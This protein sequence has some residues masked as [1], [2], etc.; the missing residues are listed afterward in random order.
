MGD[1][2]TTSSAMDSSSKTIRTDLLIVGAG[3]AGASLASFLASHNLTGILLASAPGTA[4]T[5]RAHI[6]NMA[7][8]ECLRDID[9]ERECLAL[10]SPGS[11]MQHTRWCRTMAGEEYARIYS[12]GNDP[13]RRGDYEAASPCAHVDL[14]QTLLEPILVRRA[15]QGG[16]SV[17]FETEF[18]KFERPDGPDGRIISEVRDK[19]LG[20][21]YHIESKY[22]FGCDG[23]RSQIVRQLQLPLQRKPGQGVALNILVRADLTKHLHTR[24]GN[25]HWIFDPTVEYPDW[26]WA[27]ILRMVKPWFEWMFIVLP[28]PGA[29]PSIENWREREGE[30]LAKI[31][32]WIGEDS[33]EPEVLDVSKW[34]INEIVAEEYSDE[35]ERIHCLGDAVHRHPPF[36]GLGSN[37]CIQD[38]FN[39]AWKLA[40]VLNGRAG[41]EIL[42]TY[43]EERQ[44]VGE[45]V[46]TRANQGLRDHQGWIE[47]IGMSEPDVARRKE[48][49]AEFDDPG[50]KGR[51]RRRKFQEG[52]ANTATEFHGLG[53]EMNQRYRSSA[54]F[55]EDEKSGPPLSREEEKVKKHVITTYPGSRLPHA[56]LNTRV[57]GDRISTIDLAGHGRFTLFTGFAGSEK[58]KEAANVVS[59]KVG[60]EIKPYSIGW[61]QDYEDV[62]SDWAKRSEVEE[63]GCVLV[64][65]DRFVA[66]RSA[67]MIED[68]ERKLLKVMQRV[69]SLR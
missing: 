42:R 28:A 68:C 39:L 43:S 23:A 6:T 17:R 61:K 64:R 1:F 56:W 29:D 63:D 53:V 12:W 60:V 55:L 31:K 62:Y 54:V 46:I 52:I 3:P 69:L 14:P 45:S 18:I 38:A 66:W 51:E 2:T 21:T 67:S 19:L 41:A 20:L 26:G 47:T 15:T 44:P 37:T 48:I 59:E 5:P 36:N 16:W 32:Q 35:S 9:L 22:L 30:Y 65:P 25:L 50:P 34:T 7:A 40:Y 49:L 10:A 33:V 11:A 4:F 13:A 27:C 8:L 58:W 24:T 57:P